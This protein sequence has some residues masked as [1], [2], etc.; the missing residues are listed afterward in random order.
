M[1]E[2]ETEQ[3]PEESQPEMFFCPSGVACKEFV[4]R[5]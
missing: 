1:A 3:T 5:L 2:R 4:H